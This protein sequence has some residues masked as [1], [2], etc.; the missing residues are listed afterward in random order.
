M[1]ETGQLDALHTAVDSYLTALLAISDCV[2]AACPEVG[3]T[4]GQRLSRLRSRVA[5]DSNPEAIAGSVAV[6]ERELKEYSAKTSNYITRHGVEL[7]QTIEELESIVKSIAHRQDFY[8]ARLRQFAAQLETTPYPT[9]PEH[10]S[11]VVALQA[12][13]LLGCVES[14][15]NDTQSLLSRMREELAEVTE[16]LKEAE[17]TDRLTGL[18]NRREMERQ[19]EQRRA[20]GEDPVIVVFELSGEV[21]D[22]VTQQAAARLNSQF[23]H[24]DLIC[25]WTESEFLVL[26]HGTREI[27]Q[28]RT[29][30]IVPW[31]AGKYPL[32][33]GEFVD[34][35]VEAGLV[36]P[37]LLLMQ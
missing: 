2:G 8:G 18:M 15:S 10:L 1:T 33:N 17:V 13:G 5:F 6:V 3:G 7:R 16:R 30:Q 26:F 37:N 32:E 25:R 36:A 29:D 31:I 22:E 19:I 14:M 35:G 11:E 12:A 28:A 24:Q 4:Y 9:D 21:R 23:R 27:A 20:A 34:I